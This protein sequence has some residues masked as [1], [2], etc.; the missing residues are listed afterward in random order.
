ML[1]YEDSIQW[2]SYACD[3]FSRLIGH[4][5]RS[6]SSNF[7]RSIRNSDLF[8]CIPNIVLLDRYTCYIL[9]NYYIRTKNPKTHVKS[10]EI[11]GTRGIR[12]EINWQSPDHLRPRSFQGC[13]IFL[14]YQTGLV[15]LRYG[16]CALHISIYV[17][18]PWRPT[19]QGLVHFRLWGRSDQLTR[20]T[21]PTLTS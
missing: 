2:E 21:I 5:Y 15:F 16:H 12:S 20:I 9:V 17:F 10:R 8:L 4:R 7:N 13:F 19:S 11:C 3:I 6:S 14:S 1:V 18:L